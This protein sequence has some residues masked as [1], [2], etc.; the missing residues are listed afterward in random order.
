MDTSLDPWGKPYRIDGT[1]RVINHPFSG[2]WR[3]GSQDVGSV[4]N[5]APFQMAF[6]WPIQ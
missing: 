5:W 4:V 1:G 2:T 6:L 3:M